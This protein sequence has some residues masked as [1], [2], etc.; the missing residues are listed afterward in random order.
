M[1][2]NSVYAQGA[3]VT[4]ASTRPLNRYEGWRKSTEWGTIFCAMDK[5]LQGRGNAMP[6]LGHAGVIY[7]AAISPDSRWFVTGGEDTA[8]VWEVASGTH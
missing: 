5:A 3:K 4:P 7:A 1:P 6:Q 8:K 2:G